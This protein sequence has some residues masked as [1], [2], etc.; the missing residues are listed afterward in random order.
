MME[1]GRVL[2]PGGIAIISVPFTSGQFR[3]EFRN[4][5]VSGQEHEDKVFY[6][7]TYDSAALNARLFEPLGCELEQRVFFG[8]PRLR[9]WSVFYY[10]FLRLPLRYQWLTLPFRAIMP[11]F[12]SIFLDQVDPRH[13]HVLGVVIRASAQ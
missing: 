10:R 11:I 6:E 2:R 5:D 12:S 1:I 7:R 13:P 9:F 8:E 4:Y 3:E